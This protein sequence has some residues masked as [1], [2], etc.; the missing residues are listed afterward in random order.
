VEWQELPKKEKKKKKRSLLF[1]V[2]IL[3]ILYLSPSIYYGIRDYR[4]YSREL[5]ELTK[6]EEALQKDVEALR[7]IAYHMDDP[8]IIEELAREKLF[9]V[10]PGE[11]PLLIIEE[12]EE[13]KDTLV[14]K[15]TDLFKK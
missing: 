10:R 8:Y 15:I 9:M 7:E 11:E 6:R 2:F 5:E 1:L 12:K 4:E 14:K 13:N 3:F